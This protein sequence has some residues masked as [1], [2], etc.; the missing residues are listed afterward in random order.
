MKVVPTP[1]TVSRYPNSLSFSKGYEVLEAENNGPASV[2][3]RIE[4]DQ[5]IKQWLAYTEVNIVCRKSNL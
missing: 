2:Y 5:G 4:D 3:Y 1:R